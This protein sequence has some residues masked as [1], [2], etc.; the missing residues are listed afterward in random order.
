ME[1]SVS[2]GIPPCGRK[3]RGSGRFSF[4]AKSKQSRRRAARAFFPRTFQCA[5]WRRRI[6][7]FDESRAYLKRL[8]AA[9][10]P[11]ASSFKCHVEFAFPFV[12]CLR[13]L[14]VALFRAA[15]NRSRVNN[16]T[17]SVTGPGSSSNSSAVRPPPPARR[18][19]SSAGEREGGEKNF[20]ESRIANSGIPP[21][22]T[23]YIV[24][25][26]PRGKGPA[27]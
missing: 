27:R 26:Q 1:R 19:L 14:C 25:S 17:A 6:Q 7:S 3:L 24:G 11:A 12:P 10:L 23:G 9:S 15:C 13:L 2:E 16:I 4:S 20:V 21:G 8:D 18:K 5:V 22:G